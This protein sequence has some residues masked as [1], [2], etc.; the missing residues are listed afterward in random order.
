MR[1]LSAYVLPATDTRPTKVGA[2]AALSAGGNADGPCAT[3]SRGGSTRS[4]SSSRSA[5]ALAPRGG[6]GGR[7]LAGRGRLELQLLA[8]APDVDARAA[9]ELATEDEL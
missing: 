6:R 1:L 7:Q 8:L 4:T 9:G 5:I 3:A 2:T